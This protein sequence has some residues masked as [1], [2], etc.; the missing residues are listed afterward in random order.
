MSSNTLDKLPIGATATVTNVQGDPQ[1]QQRILEMGVLPGV[2]VQ[3]V[4][5]AP[6]GDPIEI[7]VMGY[8]LSLRKAE[9]KHISVEVSS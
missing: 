5:Y 7:K 6:L 1:L 4:R 3:V 9:A 8:S 2:Q